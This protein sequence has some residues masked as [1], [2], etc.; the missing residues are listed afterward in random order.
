[1]FASEV[2]S[3]LVQATGSRKYNLQRQLTHVEKDP[4]ER[5]VAVLA[6]MTW[7]LRNALTSDLV[8]LLAC[9]GVKPL[10]LLRNREGWT[11]YQ[12]KEGV[13]GVRDLL[14]SSTRRK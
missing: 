5:K 11:T 14:R 8:P 6:S 1:M 4:S 13:G 3:E 9:R 2:Q 10:L 12:H 7:S